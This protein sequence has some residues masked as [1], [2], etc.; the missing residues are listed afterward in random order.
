MRLA[1]PLLAALAVP[2]FA[3]ADPCLTGTW[4]GEIAQALPLYQAISPAPVTSVGGTVTLV[5]DADGAAEG[6]IDGFRLAIEQGPAT[7]VNSGEGAFAMDVTAD[8]TDLSGAMTAFD[9]TTRARMEA[10]GAEPVSLAEVRHGL[11]DLPDP[12]IQTSYVCS[13]GALLLTGA[14]PAPIPVREWTRE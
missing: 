13:N 7:L 1:P 10:P 4:R 5:I 8:G 12:G 6:R 11:A 9:V 14:G 2:A 3:A